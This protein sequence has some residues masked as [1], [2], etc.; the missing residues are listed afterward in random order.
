MLYI[1]VLMCLNNLSTLSLRRH[2]YSMASAFSGCED[3]KSANF[4]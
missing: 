1:F 4:S 3:M 2:T